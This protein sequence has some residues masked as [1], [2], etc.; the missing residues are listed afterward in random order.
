MGAS[1]NVRVEGSEAAK[2]FTRE[3]A[4]ALLPRIESIF[5]VMDRKAARAR[6]LTDL[7]SDLEAYWG[8]AL[9]SDGNPDRAE[10][11]A[12][13]REI[14]GIR[15]DL[16]VLVERVNAFGCQLK[17]YHSGLV[18]FSGLVDGDVVN[19]CWQRGEPEVAWWHT[20]ESG[21]AGRRPLR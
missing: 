1:T 5:Q 12:K 3:Q 17:D 20:L 16:E 4:N 18:D 13:V 2:L 6:E 9:S 21:F 14:E 11:E 15:A 10:S 7:V 19:L 8:P